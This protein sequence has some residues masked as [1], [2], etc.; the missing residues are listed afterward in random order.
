MK[1]ILEGLFSKLYTVE[2]K[3]YHYCFANKRFQINLKTGKKR[4]KV[5]TVQPRSFI[6]TFQLVKSL[7]DIGY[8]LCSLLLSCFWIGKSF[9]NFGRNCN[10]ASF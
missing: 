6:G 8:V 9:L 3:C 5:L 4:K 1:G 2:W 10:N 7:G